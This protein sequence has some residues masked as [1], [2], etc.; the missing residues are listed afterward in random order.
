[1]NHKLT[2]KWI[3]R[4]LHSEF[5]APLNLILFEIFPHLSPGKLDFLLLAAFRNILTEHSLGPYGTV[6]KAQTSS[7]RGK[8]L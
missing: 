5:T 8:D 2:E 6:W 1:M 3:Q 7:L 4:S